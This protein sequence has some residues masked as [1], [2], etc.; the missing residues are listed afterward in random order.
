MSQSLNDTEKRYRELQMKVDSL[1]PGNLT[2]I[3]Q[4]AGDIKKEAE[5]LLNKANKG[6]EQLRSEYL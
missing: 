3:N 2:N 1:G 5:N 4:R 6:M